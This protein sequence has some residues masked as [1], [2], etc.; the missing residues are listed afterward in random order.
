MMDK[1]KIRLIK[2]F[3]ILFIGV[4]GTKLINII[5]LP[6]YTKWL[7]IEEYGSVDIFNV[8]I[9][10][11]VPILTLQLEQGIFRFLIDDKTIQDKKETISSGIVTVICIL[12]VLDIFASIFILCFSYNHYFLYL[13]AINVQSIYV[14]AQQVARGTGKNKAYSLNSII[15]SILNVAFCI[16][17]INIEKMG[18]K[19]YILGFSL[20]HCLATLVL[21]FQINIIKLFSV[22]CFR[23]KKLQKILKYS[24]PMIVNNVSWWI[25]NASDKLVLNLFCG[26]N[27]NGLYAAAGKIPNIITIGYSVF[28]MAWQESAS[29]EKDSDVEVFYS[30]IFR[31]LFLLLSF[32]TIIL[33][34]LGRILFSILINNKFNNAYNHLP[35]LLLGLFFLCLS[36]FYGGIFVGLQKSKELGI[37]SMIAAIINLIIDFSLVN[38]IGIYAASLSTFVAYFVCFIIRFKSVKKYCNITYNKKEIYCISL[39]LLCSLIVSYIQNMY[40][41]VI[42]ATIVMIGFCFCFRTIIKKIVVEMLDKIQ[43]TKV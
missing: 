19:G 5:M 37:T 10:I 36:Q 21:M 4:I 27:A 2:T 7:S 3:I 16:Y 35:I 23:I 24:I 6:F 39:L 42:Y 31:E 43:P 30:N 20:S 40:I 9:S 13:I 14:L 28:Q 15:L 1:K 22:F 17:F 38:T 11:L 12:L 26:L 34:S 25:L 41:S 32:I 33:L 18:V 8:V 29:R